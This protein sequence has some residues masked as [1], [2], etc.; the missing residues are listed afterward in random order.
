MRA[1]RPHSQPMNGGR[2]A[3]TPSRWTHLCGRDAALPAGE[4][5]ARRPHSQP[6]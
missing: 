4:R 6:V 1:R 2:Y 5:R 3:P